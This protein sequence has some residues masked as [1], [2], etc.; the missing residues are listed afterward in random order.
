MVTEGGYDS[1]S[2]RK[3]VGMLGRLSFPVLG[4]VAFVSLITLSNLFHLSAY[5]TRDYNGGFIND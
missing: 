1:L 5:L 3:K 4:L 2:G